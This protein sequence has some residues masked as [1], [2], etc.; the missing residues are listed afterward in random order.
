[1]NILIPPEGTAIEVLGATLVAL[2]HLFNQGLFPQINRDEAP[3]SVAPVHRNTIDIPA[4]EAEQWKVG[5]SGKVLYDS[6]Q[7]IEA[8]WL[9]REA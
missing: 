6:K 8:V 3:D 2:Y 5:D 9:G 4:D 7:P 1:L